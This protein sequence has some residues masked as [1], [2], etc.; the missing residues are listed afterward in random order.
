MTRARQVQ[1]V[2]P[3]GGV[4]FVHQGYSGK[5]P[6]R[7]AT[8]QGIRLE[9]VRLPQ[10]KKGF[11]LFPRRW[12]IGRTIAW[13][14]RFRRLARD[15]ERLPERLAGLHCLAFA[16]VLLGRFVRLSTRSA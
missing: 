9:V 3:S 13:V 2:K 15:Y 8:A 14:A 10:A 16:M 11:V 5:G 12:A 6:A 7:D 4:A 1:E